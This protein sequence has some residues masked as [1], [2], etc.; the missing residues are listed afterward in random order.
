MRN[1][2]SQWFIILLLTGYP[3]GCLLLVFWLAL[4]PLEKTI[5]IIPQ[6][7]D[8]VDSDELTSL[9]MLPKFSAIQTTPERKE[10]F[11]GLLRPLI[12]EKNAKILKSRTRL[13]TLHAEFLEKGL[14]TGVNQRNLEKLREKYHVTKEKY[15]ED[16]KAIAILFLRVDT[17]PPAMVIA[18]AAIES[19]WG[20]SR[21]AEEGYNLF[22]QWCY[23]AGCGIVPAKRLPGK[24]HEVRKFTSVEESVTAYY[25]NI[26]TN[27]AYKYWR[28]LRAKLRHT[29]EQF[30]GYA[31]AEGLS[32]YSEIGNPY[33]DALRKAI[34]IN[35]LE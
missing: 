14:V 20:T 35:N 10:Q 11:V 28:E 6:P 3:I 1:K 19:G 9:T 31:M 34:R 8:T 25:R 16:E 22:G 7:V 15:P 2:L 26:N 23:T 33:V 17:I 27:T 5:P 18:Q 21:F 30:T 32:K 4:H 24:T 13:M 12:E 29:P